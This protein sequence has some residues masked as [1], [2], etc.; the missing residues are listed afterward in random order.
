M[1]Y[2]EL[3]T[4]NVLEAASLGHS[5]ADFDELAGDYIKVEAWKGNETKSRPIL[6]VYSNRLL[7][8]DEAATYHSGDY[9]YHS[10]GTWMAGR[11]H[12]TEKKQ[13]ILTD[14]TLG[15]TSPDYKKQLTV[16]SDKN[17]NLY[18]KPNEF[19][20]YH[21]QLGEGKYT[22]RIYFLRDIRCDIADNLSVLNNNYIE[23][24]NFF[25]GLE[26]TQTGD[27]DHSIGHN[28]FIRM[29]NPGLGNYCLEQNGL[30]DNHYSMQV[31]G[32]KTNCSYVFSCWVAWGDDFDAGHCITDF[33][34]D[35]VNMSSIEGNIL[36][37]DCGGT[38][39]S[40]GTHDLDS[41]E[42]DGLKWHRRFLKFNIREVPDFSDEII[43]KVGYNDGEMF[44][45]SSN[46]TGRR[47]FTDLRLEKI[48]DD[49]NIDDY[50]Q[51]YMGPGYPVAS[52]PD[53]NDE[54]MHGSGS[55]S[56]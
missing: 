41:I 31:T 44:Q 21:D 38:K 39:L 23:N 55:H 3:Y 10:D 27:L 56:H 11:N 24:G 36:Q 14:I 33:E 25:A 52:T 5:S 53:N 32:L 9:H 16:Y 15:K 54:Y 40:N 18:I 12:S 29:T 1:K 49:V 50:M 13:K 43:L 35:I 8:K 26:A 46:V 34:G 20:G 48:D 37:T 45:Q 6:T 28:K 7:F 47:Y 17:D 51:K 2:I 42:I 19:M 22:L 4:D 30:G